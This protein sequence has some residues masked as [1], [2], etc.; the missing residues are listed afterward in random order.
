MFELR[1]N[2]GREADLEPAVT[3]F[4]FKIVTGGRLVTSA[5]SL[6]RFILEQATASDP[7]TPLNKI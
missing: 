1:V 7:L 5:L 6:V 3:V 2:R 4:Q